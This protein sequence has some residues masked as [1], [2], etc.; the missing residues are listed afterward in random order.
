MYNSLRWSLVGHLELEAHFR[1][2]SFAGQFRIGT[3]EANIAEQQ[4]RLRSVAMIIGA[5]LV[6]PGALALLFGMLKYPFGLAYLYDAA[7]SSSFFVTLATASL[8]LGTPLALL[9]NILAILRLSLI[10]Q[11]DGISTSVTLEP[12]LWHLLVLGVAFLVAA[13]FFGH[14]VADGFACFRG[15]KSAC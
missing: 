14:L 4:K 13:A 5:L 12:T 10:R 2:L 3:S 15:V 8:F 7:F 6:L 1:P 9:L 11:P